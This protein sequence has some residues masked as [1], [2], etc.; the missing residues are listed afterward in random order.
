MQIAYVTGSIL[1][2][3]V[4]A[5]LIGTIVVLAVGGWG[6]EPYVPWPALAASVVLIVVGASVSALWASRSLR[7]QNRFD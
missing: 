3:S 4:I 1:G 6:I 2:V 7:P 5:A